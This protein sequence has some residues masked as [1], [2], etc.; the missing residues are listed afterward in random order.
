MELDGSEVFF[1]FFSSFFCVFALPIRNAQ[2]L[3][4]R[5]VKIVESG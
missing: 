3:I 5:D 1:S 4:V 2:D